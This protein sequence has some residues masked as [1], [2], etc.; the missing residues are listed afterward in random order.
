MDRRSLALRWPLLVVSLVF[1]SIVVI[2]CKSG[3]ETITL[4]VTGYDSPPEFEG[5]KG[6]K[7]A[8]I[9]KPVASQ[10]FSS[11]GAARALA[12]GICERLKLHIKDIHL[13]EQRKV[14][15][16]VD[17]NGMEDY[18]AIGKALKAEK[19]V[20]ID[21]ESFSVLDGQTLFR[22]R[23]TISVQ[24]YDVAEKNVEW[25]KRLP[26][27]QYPRNSSTPASDCTEVDFRNKFV[28]DLAEHI[29]RLFYGHDPHEDFGEDAVTP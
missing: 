3:L 23:S 7:V 29:A 26:Q 5:L 4:L 10:E 22:G 2:G 12:E 6:K 21:I 1:L 28:S 16:L 27:I 25:R 15:K 17:E 20:G 9:C 18:A 19:V 11:T 24:V 13:I 8:V 14:D